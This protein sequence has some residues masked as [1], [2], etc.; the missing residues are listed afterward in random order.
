M[1]LTMIDRVDQLAAELTRQMGRPV[2]QT[3]NEILR[4]FQE[5]A[6]HMIDVAAGMLADIDVGPRE[7]FQRF[8]R[9]E[10]LGVVLV[11]APWN[12]P[13]LTSVNAIVP[14]IVAGNATRPKSFHLRVTL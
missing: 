6:T 13:Y 10:P 7:G 1:F 12:Y 8:I 9:R 4:G 14:A 3:P 5:R 2:R 11:L